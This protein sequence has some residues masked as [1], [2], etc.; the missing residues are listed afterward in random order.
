VS[1]NSSAV[2]KYNATSSLVRVENLSI[3]F[4]VLCKNALALYNT[5]VVV[6][7]SNIIGVA[8]E[9]SSPKC[10]LKTAP[11]KKITHWANF[12]QIW[13]PW[14]RASSFCPSLPFLLSDK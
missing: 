14:Q 10:W 1:Y 7:N 9:K 13:S 12:R 3:V 6:V 5:G 8:P 2:K 11:S 4:Y